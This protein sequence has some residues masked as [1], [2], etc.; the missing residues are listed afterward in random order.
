MPADI[1]D[2]VKHIIKKPN[3]KHPT[4]HFVI[5]KN[6]SEYG[7]TRIRPK[8]K[9]HKLWTPFKN[10][11]YRCFLMI[12]L[13]DN[14]LRI[15]HVLDGAEKWLRNK[16]YASLNFSQPQT[17]ASERGDKDQFM[18]AIEISLNSIGNEEA[19]IEKIKQLII[20]ITDETIRRGLN[21]RRKANN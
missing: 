13:L 17:F 10:P 20:D 6:S 11:R 15:H 14:T 18:E 16:G 8:A 5:D 2:L 1:K 9:E 12:Q 3:V 7:D 4:K 21:L 19:C